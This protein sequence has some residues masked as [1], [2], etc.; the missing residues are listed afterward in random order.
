MC[1]IVLPQGHLHDLIL[2]L[3]ID[4]EITRV[5][6]EPPG[7]LITFSKLDEGYIKTNI[8]LQS[9][10]VETK[11]QQIKNDVEGTMEKLLINKNYVMKL[12]CAL[13]K[14]FKTMVSMILGEH[15][16]FSDYEFLIRLLTNTF[17]L[18]HSNTTPSIVHICESGLLSLRTAH[19]AS[20]I[21]YVLQ[22]C[23]KTICMV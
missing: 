13:L 22:Y 7:Y 16:H 8:R 20:I 21:L 14:R 1:L 2:T 15:F 5:Y 4:A 17:V 3:P 12:L 11:A 19:N 6:N 9:R 10:Y 18:H 23:F